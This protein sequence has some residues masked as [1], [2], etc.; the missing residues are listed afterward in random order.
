MNRMS[1]APP[2]SFWRA[3]LLLFLVTLTVAPPSHA[4]EDGQRRIDR[5]LGFEGPQLALT[6]GGSVLM[7]W[8]R[9]TDT[10]HDLFLSRRDDRGRFGD[11]QRVNAAEGGVRIIALDEMRPA[12]ATGTE[13]RIAV[14]WLDR[15][16]QVWAARGHESTSGLGKPA[17]LNAP[18]GRP[19][20]NFAHLAFDAR[21]TLWIAWLDARDA[22]APME[23][24][25]HVYLVR[26]DE[27][28]APQ[29]EVN[30]TAEHSESVCGCCR[31]FVRADR[32]RVEVYFR[33]TSEEGYR[34]IHRVV[35]GA[36]GKFGEPERMGPATWKIEACP[37]S[38]PIA[39]P[40][41]ALWRDASTG[42]G[43]IVESIGG[44]ARLHAIVEASREFTPVNSPRTID[45][46]A[47]GDWVVL[48]PGEPAGQVWRRR[49]GR[50]S[51][52]VKELPDWCSSAVILDG[53]L[54]M[55]GDR[56]GEL[57]LEGLVLP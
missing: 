35:A 11:A 28:R 42:R 33:N 44:E 2:L 46:A 13:G 40:G 3:F 52:W 55:V 32:G 41:R 23:E 27:G 5:R 43:R 38:G 47:P 12:L 21:G 15:D 51:R 17:R 9:P 8:A 36:N 20:R 1:F 16:G 57:K 10:G 37:M 48:I 34:D 49:D 54:L 14:A 45:G 22:P 7:L 56:H 6:S 19:E 30:L 25:A 39:H 18:Q 24:P 53:Q 31:P 50:W 4:Q 26:W 29:P